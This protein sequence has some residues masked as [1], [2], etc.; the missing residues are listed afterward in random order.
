MKNARHGN[1]AIWT[2]FWMVA[3]VIAVA[4]VFWSPI[5]TIRSVNHLFGTSWQ[6]DWKTWWSVF[7]LQFIIGAFFRSAQTSVKAN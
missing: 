2:I 1:V 6:E 7:W 4:L 3:I 5:W